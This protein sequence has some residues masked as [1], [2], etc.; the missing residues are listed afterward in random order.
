MFCCGEIG[1]EDTVMVSAPF[2]QW[3]SVPH[4]A[5]LKTYLEKHEIT[6]SIK[7][8]RGHWLEEPFSITKQLF[9]KSS[10]DIVMITLGKWL[11]M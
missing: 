1:T 6:T 9:Q 2:V 11:N 7:S 5:R 3:S 4:L 10:K 8:K